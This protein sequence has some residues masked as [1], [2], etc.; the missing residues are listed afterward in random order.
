MCSPK[1]CL[2]KAKNKEEDIKSI[3]FFEKIKLN[4]PE[5][6]FPE[7]TSL[8]NCKNQINTLK[9]TEFK[10]VYLVIYKGV[11]TYY[12]RIEHFEK[13]FLKKLI[14]GKLIPKPDRRKICKINFSDDCKKLAFWQ[15]KERVKLG[16]DPIY[17]IPKNSLQST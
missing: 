1:H 3:N 2:P 4:D 15:D 16:L 14:K 12:C 6:I 17:L 8:F 9:E 11:L 10:G 13:I 5:A 7:K